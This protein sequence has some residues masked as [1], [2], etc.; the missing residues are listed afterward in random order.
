MEKKLFKVRTRVQLR[1]EIVY[2]W[3]ARS[4]G[5]ENLVAVKQSPQTSPR[6]DAIFFPERHSKRFADPTKRTIIS[7]PFR[8]TTAGHDFHLE[9]N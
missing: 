4:L 7:H 5:K 9:K 3:H 1:E 8:H 6:R 2:V